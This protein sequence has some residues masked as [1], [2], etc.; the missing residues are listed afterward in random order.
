M[1][2][3]SIFLQQQKEMVDIKNVTYEQIIDL[4]YCYEFDEYYDSIPTLYLSTLLKSFDGKE[5]KVIKVRYTNV[6]DLK[7]TGNIYISGGLIMKDTYTPNGGINDSRYYIH[8][9]NGYGEDDG[10]DCIEFYC[11]SFKIVEVSDSVY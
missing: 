11:G 4:H 8:D 10:F 2:C 7:L 9:D 6:R 3:I 5:T 1:D